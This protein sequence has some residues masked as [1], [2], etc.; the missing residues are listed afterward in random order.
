MS[1]KKKIRTLVSH[2]DVQRALQRFLKDG[3]IIHHLP[4][5]ES[6]GH[7]MVGGDKYQDYE[8]LSNLV[9]K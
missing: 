6:R 8:K 9:Q 3:G 1:Q 5:Q 7:H 2:D 4:E